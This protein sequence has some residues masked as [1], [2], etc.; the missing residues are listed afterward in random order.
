M[1]TTQ[2][3]ALSTARSHLLT[4]LIPTS[5]FSLAINTLLFV[6]PIYM[7]QIYD[8]VLSTRSVP[9][10]VAISII[11]FA[12]LSIYGVLEF[13]RTRCLARVG[14]RIDEIITKDLM[15]KMTKAKVAAPNGSVEMVV[16]DI[17]RLREFIAG[18]LLVT[19]VDM[20]WVPVYLALCF[21]IDPWLGVVATAGAAL[22]VALALLNE[23]RTRSLV[24]DCTI[25]AVKAA[26][27]MSASLRNSDALY[28][29]AMD[30][31]IGERWSAARNAAID[32]QIEAGDRA[33]LYLSMTKFVRM[34]LQSAILGV[35]AY[36]AIHQRISPG[37]ILATSI[38]M[39]KALSPIELAMGQWK[40]FVAARQGYGRL[41]Q[42]L[43]IKGEEDRLIL[44]AMRG[45]LSVEQLHCFVP[46]TQ[47]RLLKGI[48]FKL[49]AGETMVVVGPSG[50]GKTTLAKALMGLCPAMSG[51]VRLDGADLRQWDRDQLGRSVGYLPQSVQL[52]PGTVA[53]NISRFSTPDHEGIV[54]AA[55]MAG[56]HEMILSLP[57]GYETDVGDDGALLSGGQRQRIGLARAF[58]GSPKFIVLDEP[59][60]NLDTD[61]DNALLAALAA[62]RREQATVVIVSHRNNIIQQCDK[63]LVLRDGAVQAFGPPQEVFDKPQAVAKPAERR[64]YTLSYGGKQEAK[65]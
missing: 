33:G 16:S 41:N 28:A 61:G 11:A 13:I 9:T 10:L 6:S 54:T 29:M 3:P 60:S 17:D 25:G 34:A 40:L 18:P 64:P 4:A 58:Y 32:L 43:A 38:M 24:K 53:E 7:L 5:I 30:G 63:V 31:R 35:G 48:D 39:G 65:Q 47:N 55:K 44:P 2:V 62:A 59:N 23:F 56:V 12:L 49:T 20:P 50:A 26:N 57:N 37:M 15:V 36:L 21:L 27:A 19:M 14:V 52:F 46:G 45:D 8:R 51:N 22:L 42:L 1:A